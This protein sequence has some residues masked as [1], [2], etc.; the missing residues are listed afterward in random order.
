[1]ESYSSQKTGLWYC[2]AHGLFLPYVCPILGLAEQ[3]KLL[4]KIVKIIII[5][6]KP[7]LYE[8]S[9]RRKNRRNK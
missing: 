7:H 4:R 5:C 1:M 2:K 3:G 6:T 8:Q 9:L